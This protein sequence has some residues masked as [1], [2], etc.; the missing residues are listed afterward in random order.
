MSPSLEYLERCAAETGFQVIPIEKVARLGELAADV[1]RH[2]FLGGALALKGGTALNLCFGPPQR[3]SVDLDYNYIAHLEREQMIEDRPRVERAVADLARRRGYRVQQ[4]A[5]AFA[6]RKVYLRYRSV[7][8]QDDRIELDLNYL[9][10]LPLAGTETLAV[11]QPGELDRP[12]ARVVGLAELVSGKLLALLDRCAP[13]DL[14]DVAHLPGRAADAMRMPE[15]R[16]WFIALSAVL[17][18]PLTSYGRERLE[19]RVTDRTVAEQVRPMVAVAVPPAHELVERAWAVVGPLLTLEGREEA[20]VEAIQH[21]ELRLEI[22]FPDNP[23]E[24]ARIAAHPAIRWKLRNV[25]IHR[26]RQGG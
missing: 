13:R 25:R 26:N 19:S 6:G 1:A 3:L 24:A 23:D 16:A 21:G 4:S 5:D 17:E 8:G 10:R 20:Y 7:L 14:W 2:P 22:L 18:R 12:R 11:W 15:F 9:F